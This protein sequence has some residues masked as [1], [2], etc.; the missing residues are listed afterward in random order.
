VAFITGETF[1]EDKG[2]IEARRFTVDQ[3]VFYV[4]MGTIIYLRIVLA[5][6][7]MTDKTGAFGDCDVFSLDDL[8]VTACAL[9]AFSPF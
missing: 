5:F 8:R 3:G 2:V 6:L 4:A 1:I 9:K 7:E